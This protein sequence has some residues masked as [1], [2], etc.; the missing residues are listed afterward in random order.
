MKILCLIFSIL[1]TGCTTLP[2]LYQSLEEMATDDGI[3]L[4]IDKDAFQRDKDISVIVDIK[5]KDSSK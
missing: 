5:N 4:T 1:L 2:Q 3:Y